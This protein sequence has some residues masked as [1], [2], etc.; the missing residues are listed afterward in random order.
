MQ[1]Q[2]RPSL[3]AQGLVM[4]ELLHSLD[5]VPP[6]RSEALTPLMRF[7]KYSAIR[8]IHDPGS[9]SGLQG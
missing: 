9:A 4:Y 5:W 2:W 3:R 8:E 6:L 7:F 1:Y